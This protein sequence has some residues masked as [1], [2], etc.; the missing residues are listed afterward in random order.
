MPLS[1]KKETLKKLLT[2]LEARSFAKPT[3]ALLDE[4]RIDEDTVDKLTNVISKAIKATKE[5]LA[6]KN[7]KLDEV[8]Q[9]INSLISS[10]K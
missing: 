7:T 5:K 3:L 2:E 10:D 1:N 8:E 4:P 9:Q 6:S